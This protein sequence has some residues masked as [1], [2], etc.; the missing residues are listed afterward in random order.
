MKIALIV[1]QG[2]KEMNAMG[3]VAR[4]PLGVCYLKAYLCSM[5][6]LDVKIFH[7]IDESDDFITKEIVKFHPDIA[8]FST[9]SCVFST[10]VTLAKKLKDKLPNIIT[11]FG[12]E[13]ITGIF[14]DE[15]HYD[16]KLL[17]ETL[18]H[19]PVIDFVVPFE[20]ELTFFELV[21]TLEAKGEIS[22]VSGIAF[23]KNE[24]LLVAKR[25][26]RIANLDSLPIADR[27]DLP[28][29]KYHSQ[30][31]QNLD[32]LHTARGC[33]YKCSFC[34]T[35]ISNP[36]P[37]AF[38]SAKRIVKE[39]EML[40]HNHERK[41]FFFCDELFTA[42]R[43]RVMDFCNRMISSGLS[44]VIKWRVFSRVDDV[45]EKKIDLALMQEAGLSGLFFGIES[46]NAKT[47]SR[48]GKKTSPAQIYAAITNTHSNKI[49]VWCNLMI[50]YPWETERELRTSLDNYLKM[51]RTKLIKHTYIAF[52][53]PFPGTPFYRR[54]RRNNW[55]V[56]EKF[57]Q[58]DCSRPVLKTP[59]KKEILVEIYKDF[60]TKV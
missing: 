3:N 20:G 24:K 40:Y 9:M 34:A 47:L 10:S 11:V 49:E 36:G 2:Q 29:E 43:K 35:P 48:L 19:N 33:P 14:V 32:Y 59:I 5:G 51:T 45:S 31:M 55:I 22:S 57:F 26:S 46:M 54:C 38:N 23:L 8:G 17:S 56:D 37:V 18:R 44:K 28:Y 30:D 53:T 42:D 39:I 1:P 13:H 27:S 41:S 12:G 60:L 25:R 58:S 50:G 6:Y 4:P 21:K 52:I 15:T 16:S 7:Q